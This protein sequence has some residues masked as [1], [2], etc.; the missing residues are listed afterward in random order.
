MTC[1]VMWNDVVMSAYIYLQTYTVMAVKL[2]IIT[3][4][5]VYQGQSKEE[6][7]LPLYHVLCDSI[8]CSPLAFKLVFICGR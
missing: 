4:A 2:V 5:A 3:D 1:Q 7:K 8:V 6:N